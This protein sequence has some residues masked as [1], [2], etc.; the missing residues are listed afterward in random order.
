VIKLRTNRNITRVYTERAAPVCS[1]SFHTGR[2]L[3]SLQVPM[4]YI[5]CPCMYTSNAARNEPFPIS[6]RFPVYADWSK[7]IVEGKS[8]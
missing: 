1:C 3:Q 5:S 2:D 7:G 6:L 4:V 8:E